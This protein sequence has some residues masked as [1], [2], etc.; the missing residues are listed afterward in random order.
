E[1]LDLYY[2]DAANRQISLDLA[3]RR[4]GHISKNLV[5]KLVK[6]STGITLKGMDAHEFADERCDECMAG[7]MKAKPFPLR[8][9]PLRK[10]TR[11]FE[12]SH[13]DLLEGPG[14]ALDGHYGYVLV[15]IDDY[16]RYHGY[17]GFDPSIS[18]KPGPNGKHAFFG[19]M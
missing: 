1:A 10:G 2:I 18:R 19:I 8:Q 14:P 13:M 17:M 6:G 3:H 12:M 16:T 7:Q 4:L 11:P 9:P 15:I 5:K